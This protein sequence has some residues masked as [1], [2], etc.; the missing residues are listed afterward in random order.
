MQNA[1]EE[2]QRLEHAFDSVKEQLFARLHAVARTQL[3][4]QAP[5]VR[6]R[7]HTAEGHM[8][9]QRVCV[10]TY[11]RRA[12]GQKAMEHT[13][14]E[15]ATHCRSLNM[16]CEVVTIHTQ[17]YCRPDRQRDKGIRPALQMYFLFSLRCS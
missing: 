6:T 12:R 2:L 13:P 8:Y 11:G 17:S 7:Q 4:Q 10:C 16:T 15:P 1:T 14:G 9:V 3:F 5:E